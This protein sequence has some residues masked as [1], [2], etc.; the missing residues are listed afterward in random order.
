M[1]DVIFYEKVGCGN[2]TKQKAWLRAAGH[3]VI[4]KDLL[5]VSIHTQPHPLGETHRRIE[6]DGLFLPVNEEVIVKDNDTGIS[7]S[8]LKSPPEGESFKPV[9][10][11]DE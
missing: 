10:K 4:A 8:K 9:R 6:V 1:T 11:S 7:L 3:N 5:T 2:N